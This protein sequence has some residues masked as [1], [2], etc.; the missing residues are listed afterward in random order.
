M[1]DATTAM[2]RI[3]RFGT[4]SLKT[5][6]AL[7][8]GA[9]MGVFSIVFTTWTLRHVE[10]DVH[11]SVVGAQLAL[12]RSTAADID[13]K[14][15]L[16]QDAMSTIAAL[17]AKAAPA[18]GAPMDEFFL[19]R[20][21]MKKMF[22]VVIVADAEGR[23][24]YQFPAAAAQNTVGQQLGDQEFFKRV[25]SGTPMVISS[26]FRSAAG[27][28]PYIAFAA[29]LRAADGSVKGALVG[30]LNLSHGNF[31]GDLG[32]ERIGKDGYFLLVERTDNPKLVLHRQPEL[33]GTPAPGGRQHPVIVGALQGRE[34]TDEGTSSHGVEALRTFKPLRSVPWVLVAV[35]PAAEAFVGLQAR[36][37]EVLG[38]GAGLFLLASAAAWL[39]TSWLL[40]PLARLQT[41]IGRHTSDPGL[42]IEPESFGSTE[43]ADLVRAYNAQTLARREFEDRLH[44]SEKRVREIADNMPA[45]IA[46]VD[47]DERYTFANARVFA[48]YGG[49]DGQ[50]IGRTMRQLRG[51]AGYS[52]VA[53]YVAMAL[54]GQ[55]V[56]FETREFVDG[57][58]HHAQSHFI[59]DRDETGQVRGVYNMTFDITALKEAQGRQALVEQR[60]RAITDHLPALISH[61]DRNERYDFLNDTFRVWLGIDPAA[62]IGRRMADVIGSDV[63]ALLRERIARCLAGE[64]SCFERDVETLV[65]H[66]TLRIEYLPDFDADGSVA[67][68]YTLSFDV[69]EL[70]DVQLRLSKLVRSDSLTGLHNR[71]LFDET[72]PLA[73]ARSRR[74]GLGVALMFLDV[75]RFKQINDGF[76]HDVGDEVLKEFAWRLSQ[77]VRSTDSVARLGGD[78]F[79]VILEG[80][81]AEPGAERVAENVIDSIRKPFVIGERHLTV[82][83]SIG[84]AFRPSD[85]ASETA[86]MFLKRADAAL[87]VAKKNGRNRY[88][89]SGS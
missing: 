85:E 73:I 60:L 22:D 41:M 50:I 20:P 36:R 64:A 81:Q 49:G 78:E 2:P 11:S 3:R 83:T 35:Y 45:S 68:F 54:R 43:L 38:V 15:D 63:Y 71:L 48:Q 82:T 42:R 89:L 12:V 61:I 55:T 13:A 21:V 26:P 28:S 84:I 65:G 24:N 34:G 19:P 10:A 44:A 33:I 7:C 5:K 86:Q 69:T 80:L 66:K 58:S 56:N 8:S 72:L 67:G 6:F 76:G 53:P 74:S 37:Q 31:I 17:L 14:V 47:K 75:D 59:P 32:K 9:L 79:V 30:L 70:K 23:I 40:Q 87:Y 16:R 29:P 77:C 18:P 52:V 46:Y 88:H 51:D 1:P 4:W 27:D 62:S 39:L 25:K 57:H